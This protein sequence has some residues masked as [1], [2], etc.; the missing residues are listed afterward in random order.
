M[1]THELEFSTFAHGH[2]VD[3]MPFQYGREQCEPGHAFG[4]A[5]REHFLFH[6]IISGRG[7]LMTT[8][9]P[10]ARAEPSATFAS[11]PVRGFSSSLVR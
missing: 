10:R 2:Y 8:S 5:R 1:A 11:R 9:E 6:Y 4:P 7:L 3:L